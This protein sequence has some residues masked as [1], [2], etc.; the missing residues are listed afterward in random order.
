MDKII[1][2]IIVAIFL[3]CIWSGYKKGLIMGVGGLVAIVVSLIGANLLSNTFSYEIIP[4]LRPFASGFTEKQ[5]HEKIIPDMGFEDSDRSIDDILAQ[6]PEIMTEF[7]VRC[8]EDLGIRSLTAAKMADEATALAKE[9]DLGIQHAVVETLCRSVVYVAG[10]ILAFLL[11]LI[12]LVVIGNLPNLSYKI[13]NLDLVND[14]GGALCG[15]ITA[16][17]LCSVL[18]WA[19][20]FTGMIIGPD[21]VGKTFLAERLTN[22]DLLGKALGI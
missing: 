18:V 13:P 1:D 10:F 12:I 11:L 15:L 17:A 21:T 9:K 8:Y 3:I 19:A 5:I 4:A 22:L 2:I 20:K 16:V 14:I 7:C 6:N